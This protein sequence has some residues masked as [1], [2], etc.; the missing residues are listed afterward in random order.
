[1]LGTALIAGVSGIVGN[2]LARHLLG[3]GW[4]VHGLARKPPTDMAGLKP[5]EA[6]LRDLQRLREAT[7]DLRPTHVFL[8]TWLR[9]PTETENIKVN[10]A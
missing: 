3:K 4:T 10:A 6:D 8:T 7:N 9:Q 5:V 2:T 1:M